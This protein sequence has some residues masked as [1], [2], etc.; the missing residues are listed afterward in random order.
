MGAGVGNKNTP[1]VHYSDV[2]GALPI[3]NNKRYSYS[4]NDNSEITCVSCL[5]FRKI[6]CPRFDVECKG[7]CSN[8]NG[9]NRLKVKFI[10]DK[11]V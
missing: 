4:T 8:C 1:V 3:C 11:K 5:R 9:A 7:E 10:K 2:N 6:I